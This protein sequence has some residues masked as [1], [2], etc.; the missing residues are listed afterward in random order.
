MSNLVKNTVEP[1]LDP[2]DAIDIFFTFYPGKNNYKTC[3]ALDDACGLKITTSSEDRGWK[4]G[5][6]N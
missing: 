4:N 6:K 2:L 5:F 3:I 1:I